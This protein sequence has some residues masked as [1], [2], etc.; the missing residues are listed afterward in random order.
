MLDEHETH[1][2]WYLINYPPLDTG[3]NIKKLIATVVFALGA[4]MSVGTAQADTLFNFNFSNGQG[5]TAEGSF[6][7][8]DY[9]MYYFN[10]GTMG[11]NNPNDFNGFAMTIS[12]PT[13]GVFT[14][15]DFDNIY[16]ALSGV[17][18]P[19]NLVG[20][21]NFDAF[22]MD[23]ISGNISGYSNTFFSYYGNNGL[24]SET[25]YSLVSLSAVAA[26]PE[27]NA[28][29]IPQVGLLLGCL[30]FLFGRK[31]ENTGA[32]LAV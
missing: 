9:N 4:W 17:V 3:M 16:F 14:N 22:T 29:L 10:N 19:G 30:F 24:S 23:S 26:A 12:G 32:M 25:N 8:S 31:K 7:L 18:N 21:T 5:S 11:L 2:N 15:S 13:G 27:M 1:I 28:S 6:S 20:Q